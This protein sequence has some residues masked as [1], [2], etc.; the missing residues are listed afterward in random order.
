M[1]IARHERVVD[2]DDRPERIERTFGERA[3]A[4]EAGRRWRFSGQAADEIHEQFGQFLIVNRIVDGERRD[5]EF[6]D[7]ADCCGGREHGVHREINAL[8]GRDFA[9]E[10]GSDFGQ[11]RVAGIHEIGAPLQV[12]GILR[13]AAIDHA[14][15]RGRDD[16]SVSAV[17]AKSLSRCFIGSV[18]LSN[19][20]TLSTSSL[21]LLDGQR[22]KIRNEVSGRGEVGFGIL[23]E[24]AVDGVVGTLEEQRLAVLHELHAL[25]AIFGIEIIQAARGAA[26]RRR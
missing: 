13:R 23:V 16:I 3:F 8:I 17:A 14:R 2:V 25:V 6:R 19:S 12:A 9:R 21:S 11:I 15:M 20:T 26:R 24:A 4:A 22:L 7:R 1:T 5:A 18:Y 10:P